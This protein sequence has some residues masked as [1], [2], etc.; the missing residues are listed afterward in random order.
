MRV[1]VL[2]LLFCGT[3]GAQTPA[4]YPAGYVVMRDGSLIP[5]DVQP[6]AEITQASW[7]QSQSIANAQTAER[8]KTEINRTCERLEGFCRRGLCPTLG[9]AKQAMVAQ[10]MLVTNDAW[11]EGWR[12]PMGQTIDRAKPKDSATYLAIMRAAAK[13][14]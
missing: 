4:G 14:L 5:L 7:K 3:A 10:I 8:L 9:E 2:L 13:G 11:L 1:L 12:K 6:F